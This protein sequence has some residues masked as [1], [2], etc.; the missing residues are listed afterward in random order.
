MVHEAAQRVA[1]LLEQSW[2]FRSRKPAR[3]QHSRPYLQRRFSEAATRQ[4]E[5][6]GDFRTFPDAARKRLSGYQRAPCS[7]IRYAGAELEC[8]E[9]GRIVRHGTI[10]RAGETI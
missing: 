9:R 10:C 3:Y 8:E 1:S 6:A 4:Q 5:P 7:R 2:K